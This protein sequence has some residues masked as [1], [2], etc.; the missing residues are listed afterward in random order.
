[1]TTYYKVLGAGHKAIHGGDFTYTPHEWT[2]FI[3]DVIECESGYHVCTVEYLVKWLYAAD[4]VPI[5]LEVW[6]CST[7]GTVEDAGEK[8]V[9]SSIRLD[10]LVGTLDEYDLR[11]LG[12]LFTESV[13]ENTDDERVGAYI[14]TV[15][16][17][18]LGLVGENELNA[19]RS[20]AQNAAWSVV[21]SAAQN[22][23]WYAAES[24]AW[25]AA[26]SAAR[27]AAQSAAESAVVGAT[28][29]AVWRAVWHAAQSVFGKTVIDYLEG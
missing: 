8:F 3:E 1:M 20:A 6:E 29:G 4:D 12:T 13:I 5:P 16:E 15:R 23:A 14:N 24:A 27:R 19:A 25:Y 11:W 26:E 17:Y 28:G 10:R 18:C 9:V 7:D 22:A 21:G 2:P